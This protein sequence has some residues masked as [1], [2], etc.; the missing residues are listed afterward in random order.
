MR[1]D[2]LLSI[3]LLLQVNQRITAR[4]LAQRLEVSERTIH[5]DMEALGMAGIPLVAQRG[6]G[7]GWSLLEQYRTDLTGLNEAEV[8]AVFLTKPA[9]LLADLGLDKAA[10]GALIKLLAALPS[11]SRRDAEHTRQRIHI[12]G[13]GWHDAG[14]SVPLL[15]TLQ[16]AIWQERQLS[17]AY[18]RDGEVVER[19]VDPL[20][21]VAK[22]STW[23]LVA[24]V[25]GAVRTYR[26]SRIRTA[27][28]TNERCIRPANFD[29]AAYWEQSVA[30]FKANLPRYLVKFRARSEAVPWLT[31]P[32]RFSRIEQIAAAGNSGWTTLVMRFDVE[33]EACEYLLGL[34]DQVEV[35]EPITLRTKIAEQAARVI[36]LYRQPSATA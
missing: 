20:G 12:D 13:A 31:Y 2:R 32:G 10:D 8:Q 34:G 25:A 15:P 36:A 17:L 27:T 26:V 23:Y 11:V 9:Q 18:Q 19:Q 4:A 30:D 24:A 35:L 16:D 29:L 7:G 21:L 14:D 3:L 33:A 22:R 5:R 6:V 1:A 28:M